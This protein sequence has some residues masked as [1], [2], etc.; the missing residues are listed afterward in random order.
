MAQFEC[1]AA[2]QGFQI[3]RQAVFGRHDGAVD[4]HRD[5]RDVAL[6]RR[7]EFDAYG[8]PVVVEPPVSSLIV[9]FDPVRPDHGKKHVALRNLCIELLGEIEA[10]LHGIDIHEQLV[11]GIFR[12]EIIEQA[13]GNALR[14]VTTVIDKDTRHSP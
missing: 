12:R 1:V 14:V 7:S 3:V 5:H 10:G 11:A 13:P 4:Q 8:I 9:R 6:Q 2:G